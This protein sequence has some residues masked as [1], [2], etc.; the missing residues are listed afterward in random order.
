MAVSDYRDGREGCGGGG[1]GGAIAVSG[2]KEALQFFTDE[3]SF[4][5]CH[6]GYGLFRVRCGDVSPHLTIFWLL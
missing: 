1:G 3:W 6:G 4:T 2:V 5:L